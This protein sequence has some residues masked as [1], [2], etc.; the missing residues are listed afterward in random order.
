MKRVEML[1]I[2]P[3]NDFCNPKGSLFVTGADRDSKRLAALLTRI[4]S[5]IY[6][7]HVTLDTH[8]WY[9]IAHPGFWRDNKGS[10]PQPFT[11]ISVDDV[12]QNVWMPVDPR[13][14]MRAY[15]LDYVKTLRDNNRYQLCVW[16]VHCLIG[17]AGNNVV[18]PIQKALAQWEKENTAMV[19]YVTKGSNYKTEHY[20]ALQA[21]VP[22]PAD[23]ATMLNTRLIQTL[24]Q[25]DIIAL[26]GQALSHCV[27]NTI[28]DIADNFGEENI[29]KLVLLED[30][31]SAV[32]GFEH[33]AETFMDEMTARGM[34]TANSKNFLV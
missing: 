32:P 9:D 6:D 1:I 28:R 4:S 22:D 27:A 7:I 18:E 24:E 19:N 12:E 11:Q 13:K 20:S 25:A 8:H 26:S 23:P 10:N 30:T 33:L 15:A 29:Q 31:T 16:P 34:Q 2:D 17:T 3:Q 14:E 21:D 5:M